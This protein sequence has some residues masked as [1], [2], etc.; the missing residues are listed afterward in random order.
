M[1]G[2]FRSELVLILTVQLMLEQALPKEWK[3]CGVA[4][5][6]RYDMRLR[7][8]ALKKAPVPEYLGECSHIGY[9]NRGIWS[10]KI[11]DIPTY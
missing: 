2:F 5:S 1:A 7:R 6:C 10:P 11:T 9:G 3:N 8:T 4:T